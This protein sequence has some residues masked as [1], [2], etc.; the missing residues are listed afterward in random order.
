MAQRHH[1]TDRS[2]HRCPDDVCRCRA[3]VIED[4]DGVV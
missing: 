1:L 2:A 3:C 4:G